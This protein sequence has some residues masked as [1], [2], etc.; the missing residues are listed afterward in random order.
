[1]EILHQDCKDIKASYHP[2]PGCKP[3]TLCNNSLASKKNELTHSQDIALEPRMSTITTTSPHDP[4]LVATLAIQNESLRE[5]ALTQPKINILYLESTH[6]LSLEK[7]IYEERRKEIAKEIEL[8][9]K[10]AEMEKKQKEQFLKE[11]ILQ[12]KLTEELKRDL[13]KK[14]SATRIGR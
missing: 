2:S 12:L 14:E 1:M 4:K 11:M 9:V 3:L 6:K 5:D 10:K 13:M 8:R 7:E